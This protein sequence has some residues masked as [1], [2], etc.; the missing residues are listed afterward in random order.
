MVVQTRVPALGVVPLDVLVDVRLCVAHALTRTQIHPLVSQA[1]P[2]PLDEHIVAP[3]T[4][5]IHAEL[6][7][8][9]AVD[10]RGWI[11]SERAVLDSTETLRRNSVKISTTPPTLD[12]DLQRIGE[13]FSRV[14][15]KSVAAY[16][17][18]VC[19]PYFMTTS[20]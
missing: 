18:E 9:T 11:A 12:R 7:T 1:T 19:I 14:W 4:P 10:Q 3:R 2:S 20:K 13:R 8:A 5:T 16:A 17:L 6:R 15:V